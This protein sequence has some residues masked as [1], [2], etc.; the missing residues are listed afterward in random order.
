MT[1]KEISISKKYV[2]I[3]MMKLEEEEKNVFYEI[4]LGIGTILSKKQKINNSKKICLFDIGNL[5]YSINRKYAE[6]IIVQELYTKDTKMG[7]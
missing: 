7:N 3:N 6:K 1:L 4:G 5:T 2:V